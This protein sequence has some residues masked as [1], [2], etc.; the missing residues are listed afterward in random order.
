[1]RVAFA[2]EERVLGREPA[3]HPLK[4]GASSSR[5][6]VQ[7]ENN[8]IRADMVEPIGEAIVPLAS[9]A[10]N[11]QHRDSMA[12]ALVGRIVAEVSVDAKVGGVE[13]G[14]LG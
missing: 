2:G 9:L 12:R 11:L 3:K 7:L 4:I 5:S 14:I 10:V 1:M 6:N 8:L 13:S